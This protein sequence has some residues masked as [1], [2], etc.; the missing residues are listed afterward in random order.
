MKE[1]VLI[2]AGGFSR[3]IIA[4]LKQ[5][6]K[7]FV[8]DAYFKEGLF[9]ISELNPVKHK[10]LIAIG[11]PTKRKEIIQVFIDNV[12]KAFPKAKLYVIK[13][14]KGWG[15]LAIIQDIDIK[16]DKYYNKFQS[17][18]VTILSNGIGSSKSHPDQ[19]TPGIIAVAKEIDSIIVSS[20]LP[21][22]EL[23]PSP[24]ST[25][26]PSSSITEVTIPEEGIQEFSFKD[27]LPDE[28]GFKLFDIVEVTDTSVI[29]IKY[30]DPTTYAIYFKTKIANNGI[31]YEKNKVTTPL[32]T[33]SSYKMDGERIAK[34]QCEIY[35][36]DKTPYIAQL[37]NWG[38]L[39]TSISMMAPACGV[40]ITQDMFYGSNLIRKSPYIDSG[41][42]LEITTLQKNFSSLKRSTDY[43]T[44][45]SRA[46]IF[47]KYKD[48]IRSFKK[49]IVIRM[50]GCRNPA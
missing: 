26:S 16:I 17:E 21:S 44:K 27:E 9:K 45:L 42:N 13:G 32:S 7:C 29:T 20:S 4:D 48:N 35:Y 33:P 10:V 24:T 15:N 12:K 43:D 38:C 11:D 23:K 37:N 1:K 18:G 39:V 34:D 40:N 49:P 28:E 8:D 14:T 19:K 5:K 36:G 2:G 3:E 50:R 25:P 31:K 46:D 30:E 47:E 6:L 22:A 41:N